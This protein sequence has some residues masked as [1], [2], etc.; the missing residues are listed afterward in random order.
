MEGLVEVLEVA[1]HLEA[2]HILV[3]ESV[4]GVQDRLLGVVVVAVLLGCELVLSELAGEH[5][6]NSTHA[7]HDLAARPK[8]LVLRRLLG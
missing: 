7:P 8:L 5:T 3:A 4:L 2:A 6:P 1:V